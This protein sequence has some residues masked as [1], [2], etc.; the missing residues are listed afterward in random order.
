MLRYCFEDECL[1]NLGL[2]LRMS[3][4]ILGL[5]QHRQDGAGFANFKI[6]EDSAHVLLFGTH[7]CA[8]D[9]DGTIQ[10]VA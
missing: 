7:P 6:S 1:L 10:P 3:G 2:G 4:V 9:L 8:N 5:A